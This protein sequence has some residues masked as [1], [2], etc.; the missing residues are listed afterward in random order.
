MTECTSNADCRTGYACLQD[1]TLSSGATA[2]YS[3]GVCFPGNCM[4]TG[5]PDGYTCQAVTDSSGATRN[6][7]GR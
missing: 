1:I 5:C 6:V 7:C 2:S 3:N 4:T